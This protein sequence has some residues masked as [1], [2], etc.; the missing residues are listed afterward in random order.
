MESLIEYCKKYIE[1]NLP[2][3]EGDEVYLDELSYLIIEGDNANGT[4][5]FSTNLA[6]EYIKEW[7]DDAAEY[8]D[9]E[10]DYFG[11]RSNPFKNAERF[12]LNIVAW[13]IYQMI[14]Y[15]CIP[16]EKIKLSKE[17]INNIIE[18]INNYDDN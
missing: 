13:K 4:L 12:M 10:V 2:E 11:K 17:V 14:D 5:T 1:T 6:K 18:N 3:F 16:Y 15:C 8:S 9:W 7:W